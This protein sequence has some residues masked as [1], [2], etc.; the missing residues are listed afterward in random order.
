MSPHGHLDVGLAGDHHHRQQDSQAANLFQ[1]SEAIFAGHHHVREHEVEGLRFHQVQP[2]GRIVA[3]GGVVSGQTEGAGQ[4]S[5]G[6]GVV[7]DD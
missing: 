1:K 3:D 7:I 6:I 4:R 5:Q 2:A